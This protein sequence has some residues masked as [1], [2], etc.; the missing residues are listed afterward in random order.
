MKFPNFF[1][2]FLLLTGAV[3]QADVQL[4]R[5][6][7]DTVMARECL[8]PPVIDGRGDEACWAAA[9]WQTIDQIWIPWGGTMDPADFTGRYKVIWS[10][11]TDR[12]YFLVEIVDDVLVDGY[13]FPQDGYYNWDVVELFFDEDASGGDHTLNQNAFAY[14]ITAGNAD[15]DYEVM[16]LT[17]NY[18]VK[19]Y[20][21]HLDCKIESA[22]GVYLWEIGL[23]VYNE[24]YNPNSSTNPTEQLEI[25]KVSG[26]SIAYCDNDN[27]DE[28]PKSRDNF[29]GSVAVSASRNNSHWQDASDFGT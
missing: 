27:P 3:A 21:H 8:T 9:H 1:L 23:I 22:D 26:L 29:I 12:I 14:H 6:Q 10:S 2:L 20:S 4:I 16:D 15:V 28:N 18:A 13:R 19:N 24:D 11:A 25:G 17:A 7:D 5:T